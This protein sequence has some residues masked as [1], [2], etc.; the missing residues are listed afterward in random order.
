MGRGPGGGPP[1]P[2]NLSP[3]PYGFTFLGRAKPMGYTPP[4]QFRHL[5][6]FTGFYFIL[7]FYLY[8]NVFCTGRTK[9]Y[10]RMS[11]L[12]TWVRISNF[13]GDFPRK[14]WKSQQTC[15][16]FVNKLSAFC[17]QILLFAF[18]ERKY[19]HFVNKYL[20]LV[21]FARVI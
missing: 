18:C 11:G 3:Y 21:L 1:N 15:S 17:N 6:I 16:H 9:N 12:K 7:I 19:L 20:H 14:S 13:S 8:M 2:R 10:L 4:S 5:N